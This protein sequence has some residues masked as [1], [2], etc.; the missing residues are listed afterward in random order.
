[1]SGRVFTCQE[2]G[3]DLD[4]DTGLECPACGTYADP[5]IYDDDHTEA[6]DGI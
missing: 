2:C 4:P 1:V 3:S 5:S 6:P